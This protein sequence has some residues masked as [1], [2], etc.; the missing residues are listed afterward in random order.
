M[1]VVAF[2]IALLAAA[3]VRVETTPARPYVEALPWV[4]RLNFDFVVRNDT[5][6]PFRLDRIEVSV[7]DGESALVCRKGLGTS[8]SSPG[9]RTLNARLV[10][11][12]D[13]ILVF[14]PF[15]SWDPQV[16]LH[17]LVY[18]FTLTSE[19]DPSDRVEARLE[20]SPRDWAPRTPLVLPLRGRFLVWDGHDFLSHHRRWD[21]AEPSSRSVGLRSNVDRFAYDLSVVDSAGRMFKGSGEQ[22]E[23]WLGFGA[24]VYAPGAGTVVEAVSDRPDRGSDKVDWDRVSREPSVADGNFV[25]VDHGNGEWSALLHLKQ[26]SVSVVRGQRVRRGQPIGQMGFSGDAITV[27]LHYRLQAG[28]GPDTEGLPSIFAGF[29]RVLGARSVPVP[30]GVIDTGDIIER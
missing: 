27:H 24:T 26:G 20:V 12:G 29:R 13:W 17:R 6:R 30:R 9:I 21:L 4:R 22:P 1:S 5:D 11:A 15:H 23:D 7:L 10:P 28:P 25:L 19:R 18:A 3:G 8:G 14:N 2:G 16:P